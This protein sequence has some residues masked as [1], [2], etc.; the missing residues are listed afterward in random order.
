MV[1]QRGFEDLECFSLA[2]GVVK[3]TYA[4]AKR[5]PDAE[6]YNLVSQM[7]RSASSVTLNIAEGYGRFHYLDCLRF[8]YNARGSLSETLAAF[9][10]CEAVGYIDNAELERLRTMVHT[11]LRSLNG[12]IRYVRN[13]KRGHQEYGAR[14]IREDQPIYQIPKEDPNLEDLPDA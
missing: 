4:L 9:I 8:Y 1:G 13:Q 5:L 6:R 11:A 3:E 7:Q 10:N 12:Y 14:Q 2:L